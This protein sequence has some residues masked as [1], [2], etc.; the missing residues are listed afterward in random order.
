MQQLLSLIFK[1]NWRLLVRLCSVVCNVITILS[2]IYNVICVIYVWSG[3]KIL[4][5]LNTV[6]LLLLF[7]FK[8]LVIYIVCVI[9]DVLY[10]NQNHQLKYTYRLEYDDVRSFQLR[11][12]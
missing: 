11:F 8:E 3:Y 6:F 12:M 7:C 5:I 9:M 4:I 1:Q 10:L 2:R